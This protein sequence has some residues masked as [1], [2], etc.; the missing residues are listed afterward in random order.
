MRV[1]GTSISSFL[2]FLEAKY[3]VSRCRDFIASLEPNLRKRC[4]GLILASAFYPSEDLEALL[5]AAQ[6][7][8]GEDEGFLGRSGAHNAAVGLTGVHQALLARPTPVDFLRAA[9]RSWGQFVDSGTV[10]V[11]LP[12]EGRAVIRIDGV[13]GSDWLCARETGFLTRSLELA[14]ARSLS[15]AK[16]RCT[17]KGDPACEWEVSWDAELSPRPQGL[18]TGIKRPVPI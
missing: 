12:S 5:R 11:E 18:T 3:G 8:L 17:V 6:V 15:V 4:E 1:K 16:L 13:P 9:E 10:S 14:G 2:A 7:F